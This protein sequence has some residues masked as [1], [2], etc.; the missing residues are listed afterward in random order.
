MKD[1][2]ILQG[3]GHIFQISISK[4]IKFQMQ[5]NFLNCSHNIQGNAN[6][7]VAKMKLPAWVPEYI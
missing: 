4:S 1:I 6:T 7:H 3:F 2:E 5:K